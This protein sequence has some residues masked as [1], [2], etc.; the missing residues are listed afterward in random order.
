[1]S[2]AGGDAIDAAPSVDAAPP[3][4]GASPDHVCSTSVE[5]MGTVIKRPIDFIILP[6]ESASMGS[7]RDAVA[8]AM[9][10]TFRT[11]METAGIDYHVIWHGAWPLP[12][13]A[14][15]LTYNMLALGSGDDVM[16]AP[17]LDSYDAWSTAVRPDAIKV[18]VHF[19]DATSGTGAAITGYTGTFD[20]VLFAR[21][22]AL[23]GTAAA[24]L[25]SYNAFV[26]LTEN[27]PPDLP[28]LPGD[29]IVTGTCSKSFVDP[30]ELQEMAQRTGGL[31]FPLCRDDLFDAVFLRMASSAVARASVPCELVL[32]PPPA[33]ST[34]DDATVAVRYRSGAGGTEVFLRSASTAECTDTGFLLVGD[35]VTLCPAACARVSA[36]DMATLTVLSGCDPALY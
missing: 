3:A 27:T 21:D 18:V 19:T 24:P 7:A 10:T 15:H 29:P 35:H 31:R 6:D 36:D 17:V 1:M 4:D 5:A 32:P 8:N 26:G 33:G 16:F 2:D 23:W 13:L 14:G 25:F 22:P 11:T 9:Q 34:R 20:E 28:Y 30:V 12:M